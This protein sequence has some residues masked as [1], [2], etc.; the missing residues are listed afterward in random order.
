[1][2]AASEFVSFHALTIGSKMSTGYYFS[3]FEEFSKVAALY[4]MEFAFPFVDRD[5]ISFVMGLPPEV[6]S[7]GAV[8]RAL[9]RQDL[10]GVVPQA[11]LDRRSK[12]DFT[13]Y[14]NDT[15]QFQFSG[16]VD[17][18]E[19]S[20]QVVKRGYVQ[21]TLLRQELDLMKSQMGIP[22]A[23][24]DA[25]L[26]LQKLYRLELWLDAFFREAGTN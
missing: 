9:I 18:F 23:T 25:A 4:G 3:C 13:S 17:S 7:A 12:G 20:S 11:I 10:R 16:M 1:M 6:Y 5:V 24:C 22:G 15:V 2:Q 8:P 19:D 21:Q 26:R 14:V